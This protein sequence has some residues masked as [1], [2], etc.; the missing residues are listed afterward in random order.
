MCDLGVVQAAATASAWVRRTSISSNVTR[1]GHA[2][3][4]KTSQPATDTP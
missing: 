3:G 1:R 4:A 2:T